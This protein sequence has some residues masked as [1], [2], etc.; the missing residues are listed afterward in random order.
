MMIKI[1][2][3]YHCKFHNKINSKR[4]ATSNDDDKSG[5]NRKMQWLHPFFLSIEYV[6][7]QLTPIA[8]AIVIGAVATKALKII[9]VEA[10]AAKELI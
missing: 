2:I 10:I 8:R 3:K 9:K 1:I 5:S 4:S 6:R 7:F